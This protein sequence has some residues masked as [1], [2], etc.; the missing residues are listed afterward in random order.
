MAISIP[1]FWVIVFALPIAI[2]MGT[3][4]L[5]RCYKRIKYL[6]WEDDNNYVK[7]I[8]GLAF[9]PIFVAILFGMLTLPTIVVLNSDGGYNEYRVFG[10]SYDGIEL[11]SEQTYILNKSSEPI[12]Y[13]SCFYGI[14]YSSSLHSH[15][16]RLVTIYP[17]DCILADKGVYRI[18][19]TPPKRIQSRSL[20]E[21][22]LGFILSLSQF[23]EYRDTSE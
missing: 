6:G 5:I 14:A 16:D 12:V 19:K 1:L 23:T 9:V 22:Y 17:D 4:F 11:K 7:S 3:F 2:V 15:P 21:R 10:S 20:K 8:L 13:L 18:L